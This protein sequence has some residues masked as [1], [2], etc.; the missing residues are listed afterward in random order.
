MMCAISTGS[1]VGVSSSPEILGGSPYTSLAIHVCKSALPAVRIP[2]R[3]M[4]S[5]S[6]QYWSALHMMAAFSVRWKRSKSQLWGGGRL[7][8]RTGCHT[9]WPGSGRVKIQTDVPGRW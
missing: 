9:A 5:A 6:V 8:E 1:A 7:S 4:G 3:T 2:R